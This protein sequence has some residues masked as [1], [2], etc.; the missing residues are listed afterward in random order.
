MK[1]QESGFPEEAAFDFF[2]S[3]GAFDDM[4]QEVDQIDQLDE[5]VQRLGFRSMLF[6][7]LT[8][9]LLALCVLG[10]RSV[11]WLGPAAAGG[12]AALW[13]ADAFC[14]RRRRL[15]A[16][17]QRELL[18]GAPLAPDLETRTLQERFPERRM[19][20]LPCFF[21]REVFGFYCPFLGMAL[22]FSAFVQA[23]Q[24]K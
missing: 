22:L 1:R 17:L 23:N 6:K 18:L 12:I 11:P 8:V 10:S 19:R 14:L 24:L 15:E 5:D 4:L 21:S 9:A 7:C 20:W 13:V 3:G 16:K 2:G